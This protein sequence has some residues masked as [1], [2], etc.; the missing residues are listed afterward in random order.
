MKSRILC[1]ALLSSLAVTDTQGATVLLH[2]RAS[3]TGAVVYLG[4]IADISSATP[5]EV[6]DLSTTPLL[7]AP[8]QG[9]KDYLR[10]NQIRELLISRGVDVTELLITGAKVV[11]ISHSVVKK[12]PTPADPTTLMEPQEIED[13]VLAA[14][15]HYLTSETG[16]QQ[17]ELELSL[18][19]A[20]LNK[21]A[22]LGSELMATAGHSPWT[23]P[24]R[25][26]ITGIGTANAV[27]VNATVDRLQEA[28]V[29]VRKIQPGD[30]IGVSDVEI[31]LQ[32]GNM[33][34]TTVSSLEHVLG[35]EA[36]RA[37]TPETI[38]QIG[39]LRAPLQVQRGE[40]VEVFAR[41][42][43]ITVKTFAVVKQDGSLGDLVQ[44]ETL[45]RKEKFAARVSGWKQLDVLPTG[46]SAADVATLHPLTREL[47]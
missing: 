32:G 33:P 45:D 1:L 15:K 14:I 28:V 23:G 22:K 13:A 5:N 25:F 7:P 6:N 3:Y 42:G 36:I 4:D 29:A 8:S 27:L 46:V 20:T 2:E 11:E 47:R 19:D 38:L 30:L 16:H 35:K 21:L 17:W 40:T 24:Q 12:A 10:D 44:V 26:Q 37:I 39:Q 41:T 34:A 43:G 18:T 9:T 31:R